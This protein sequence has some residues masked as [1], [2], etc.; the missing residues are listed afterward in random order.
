MC[1]AVIEYQLWRDVCRKDNPECARLAIDIDHCD[2]MESLAPRVGTLAYRCA[3][4][5]VHA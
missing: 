3:Q 2:A 4:L 5:S 1:I